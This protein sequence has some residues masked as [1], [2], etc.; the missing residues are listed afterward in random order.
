[1]DGSGWAKPQNAFESQSGQI[2]GQAW[3]SIS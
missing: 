1:M 3:L 2:L